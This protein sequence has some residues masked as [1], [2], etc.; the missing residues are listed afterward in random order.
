L[1]SERKNFGARK[2]EKKKQAPFPEKQVGFQKKKKT[3]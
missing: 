2:K 3:L 1:G